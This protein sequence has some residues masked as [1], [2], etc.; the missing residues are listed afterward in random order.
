MPS[1]DPVIERRVERV[2]VCPAEVTAALPQRVVTP[3]SAAIEA[4]RETLDWVAARFAR[5]EQL[6]RRLLD[7]RG[8][9][10]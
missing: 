5:E 7:A 4:S 3:L 6:E 1:A 2:R 8:A 9:C 10:Q